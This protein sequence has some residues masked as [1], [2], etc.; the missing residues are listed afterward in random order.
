[1][2]MYLCLLNTMEHLLCVPSFKI[3]THSVSMT[4]FKFPPVG[5]FLNLIFIFTA[6]QRNRKLAI[7]VLRPFISSLYYV[8]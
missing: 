5:V 2:V 3:F 8:V 1:M 6:P 7:T 4:V